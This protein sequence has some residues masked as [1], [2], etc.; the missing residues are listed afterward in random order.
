MQITC[1]VPCLNPPRLQAQIPFLLLEWSQF[2]LLFLMSVSISLVFSLIAHQ[3]HFEASFGSSSHLLE[4]FPPSVIFLKGPV[5]SHPLKLCMLFLFHF[6]HFCNL[7][8][9]ASSLILSSLSLMKVHGNL[10]LNEGGGGKLKQRACYFVDLPSAED[11]FPLPQNWRP[12]SHIPQRP[13]AKLKQKLTQ[14]SQRVDFNTVIP[15]SLT[16]PLHL[17]WHKVNIFFFWQRIV[18]LFLSRL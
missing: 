7:F 14:R 10:H 18:T 3:S 2:S 6:D 16:F 4:F 17:W 8:G 12:M 15:E 1:L 5:W 11:G 9:H 13:P